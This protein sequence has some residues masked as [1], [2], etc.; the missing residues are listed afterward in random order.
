M[1]AKS[2]WLLQNLEGG[3]MGGTLNMFCADFRNACTGLRFRKTNG[4][5]FF[6]AR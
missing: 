3:G 4:F 5:F 2:P 1:V 6:F